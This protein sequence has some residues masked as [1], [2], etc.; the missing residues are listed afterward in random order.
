MGQDARRLYLK[1]LGVCAAVSSCNGFA[2]APNETFKIKYWIEVQGLSAA[3]I[4][5]VSIGTGVLAFSSFT[6]AGSLSDRYGRKRFLIVFNT[7]CGFGILGFYLC[8][9]GNPLV[10]VFNFISYLAGFVLST[11]KMAFMA[12]LFPTSRRAT[13]QGVLVV[14]EF[15]AGGISLALESGL[16]SA[17]NSHWTATAIL[18]SPALISGPLIYCLL[19]ETSSQELEALSPESAAPAEDCD[20]GVQHPDSYTPITPDEG[21]PQVELTRLGPVAE[22]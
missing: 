2:F 7:M 8:Q 9:R 17:L 11:V 13:A 5:M 22:T 3:Q 16:Y 4:S 6:L 20:Q 14:A 19:P 21:S 18:A 15:L 10:F 1:R 12:E